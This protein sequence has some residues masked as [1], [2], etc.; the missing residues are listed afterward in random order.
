MDE[1]R[2]ERELRAAFGELRS[3]DARTTPAFEPLV[4][5][6]H[7]RSQR[8]PRRADRWVRL[9]GVAVA[10][11]ILVVAVG[12]FRPC[13]RQPA[14]DVDAWSALSQWTASTDGFLARS[15]T[16]VGDVHITTPSDAWMN[17]RVNAEGR[18]SNRKE[19][20]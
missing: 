1:D 13:L 9:S 17:T 18:Q 12:L 19:T 8:A 5:S 20:L 7:R 4:R 3:A 11:S 10:V 14:V 6:A 16:D 2:I 15:G